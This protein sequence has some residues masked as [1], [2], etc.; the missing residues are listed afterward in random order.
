MNDIEKIKKYRAVTGCGLREAM[1]AIRNGAKI[2]ETKSEIEQVREESNRMFDLL[3][4][5]RKIR[6]HSG[7]TDEIRRIAVE[8]LR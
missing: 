4:A 2:P 8:A 5:L 7:C 1:I 3:S 6:D